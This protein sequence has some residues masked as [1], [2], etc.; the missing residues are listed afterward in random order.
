MNTNVV[1]SDR[2]A[3]DSWS[4]TKIVVVALWIAVKLAI[5]VLLARFDSMQF[6]YAGF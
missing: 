6:V 3:A 5:V 2:P 4:T 1:S